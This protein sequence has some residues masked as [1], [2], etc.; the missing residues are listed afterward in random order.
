ML[1]YV[2]DE[3]QRQANPILDAVEDFTT[4]EGKQYPRDASNC[5]RLKSSLGLVFFVSAAAH[6]LKFVNKLVSFLEHVSYIE[7][8]TPSSSQRSTSIISR[9]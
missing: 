9:S 2:F 6:T 4:Y 7:L 3:V 5:M 1:D 8:R